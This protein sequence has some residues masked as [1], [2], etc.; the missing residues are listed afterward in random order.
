MSI[1]VKPIQSTPMLSGVDARRIID[2]VN[3]APSKDK[4]E[5]NRKRLEQRRAIV[6]G[7]YGE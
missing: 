6:I 1:K 4:I 5:Q 7:E 3:I 2:Q